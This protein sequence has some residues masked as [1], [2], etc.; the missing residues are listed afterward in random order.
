M[1]SDPIRRVRSFNRAV[2]LSVGALQA[3]YLERGR[4]LG[5]AR[6]LFEVGAE[7]ADLRRL[8]NEARP[9]FRLPEPDGAIPVGPG[10]HRS[11]QGSRATAGSAGSRSTAKGREELLAYDRLSDRLAASMLEPLD[12]RQRERLIAAMGEVET[13]LARRA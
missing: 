12:A 5:E 4:P 11:G 6:L 1:D 10:A 3:S 2:T 13:L 8:E 9:R 7:G